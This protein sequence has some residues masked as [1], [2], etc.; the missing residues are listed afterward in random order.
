VFRN[1]TVIYNNEFEPFHWNTHLFFFEKVNNII[2]EGNNFGRDLDLN[3]DIRTE[4]S[5][6]NAVSVN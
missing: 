4:L 5:E 1:N 2:I 6:P 3:E